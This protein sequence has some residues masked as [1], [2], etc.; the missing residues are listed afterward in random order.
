MYI[1][2]KIEP[3][4]YQYLGYQEQKMAPKNKGLSESATVDVAWLFYVTWPK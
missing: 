3:I 2:L 4:V 1:V